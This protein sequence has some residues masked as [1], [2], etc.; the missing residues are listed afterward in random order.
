[1]SDEER[2]E[3]E[4]PDCGKKLMV[5]R[6]ARS[7]QRSQAKESSNADLQAFSLHE[8]AKKC[9]VSYSALWRA[10]CQGKIK[11]LKGFGRMMVS[12]AELKR[13][14]SETEIYNGKRRPKCS[15][16]DFG[17]SRDLPLIACENTN[18]YEYYSNS[19]APNDE[20]KHGSLVNLGRQET[21]PSNVYEDR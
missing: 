13:F 19:G 15:R 1:M 3:I 5:L 9:G 8:A 14:L 21:N 18:T 17:V 2:L 6:I 7:I 12:A 4:C 11:V 20:R 16:C 10:A